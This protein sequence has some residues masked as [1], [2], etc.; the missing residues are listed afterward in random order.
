MFTSRN[1]LPPI[2]KTNISNSLDVKC[3]LI[4]KKK[5]I[6]PLFKI[7]FQVPLYFKRDRSLPNCWWDHRSPH[8]LYFCF[9]FKL[10][11]FLDTLGPP[12][13]WIRHRL[14]ESILYGTPVLLAIQVIYSLKFLYLMYRQ[15]SHHLIF[16]QYYFLNLGLPGRVLSNWLFCDRGHSISNHPK[17]WNSTLTL[18]DFLEILTK[19]DLTFCN[20]KSKILALK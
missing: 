3:P 1:L 17:K 6:S 2:L 20:S 5:K 8:D 16:S 4:S 12:G 10:F 7:H 18:S 11:Q 19:F 15:A 13:R 9:T 14:L